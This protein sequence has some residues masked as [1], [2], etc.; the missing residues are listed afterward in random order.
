MTRPERVT[1]A[2]VEA[3]RQY[4]AAYLLNER[5]AGHGLA[6]ET[7]RVIDVDDALQSL[8]DACVVHSRIRRRM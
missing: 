8:R 7:V 5:A 3:A 2:L 4:V 1:Q 6:A